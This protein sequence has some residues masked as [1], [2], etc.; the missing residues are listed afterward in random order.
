M[1]T[2]L[3]A[4]R[5][6]GRGGCWVLG[7]GA[8]GGQSMGAATTPGAWGDDGGVKIRPEPPPQYWYIL[9]KAT[10]G[11]PAWVVVYVGWGVVW[12]LLWAG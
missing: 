10:G 1:M 3:R 12:A 5:R 2:F 11:V 8:V 7:G 6:L 9:P 4:R